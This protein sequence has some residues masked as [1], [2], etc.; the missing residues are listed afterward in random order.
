MYKNR[1]TTAIFAQ[2]IG[3]KNSAIIIGKAT[4]SNIALLI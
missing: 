3:I 4:D 2:G 1:G